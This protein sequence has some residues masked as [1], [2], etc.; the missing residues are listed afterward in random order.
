MTTEARE[1]LLTAIARARAW[2]DDLGEGRAKSFA[3][4]A[5]REGKIERHIRNLAGLAFVSPRIISAIMEQSA[6]AELT[7]TQL[8]KALPYSW[9]EQERQV[10]LPE[11]RPMLA[12]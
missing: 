12:G 7:V 9:D 4:I 1:T 10:G 11:T 5:N 8:A 3:E 2:I 6:P